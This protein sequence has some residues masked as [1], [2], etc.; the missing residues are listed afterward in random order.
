MKINGN[1]VATVANNN[2]KI[3]GGKSLKSKFSEQ[4]G[5]FEDKVI[6]RIENGEPVYTMGRTAMTETDWENLMDNIDSLTEEEQILFANLAV[7]FINV[8][9]ENE[10]VKIR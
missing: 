9:A 4:V 5:L 3:S 10:R 2:E 6:D 7:E 1:Y 8:Q